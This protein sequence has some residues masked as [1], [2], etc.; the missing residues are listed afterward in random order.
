[1]FFNHWWLVALLIVVLIIFGPGKLPQIGG[2]VGQ[3]IKE[4]RR[5]SNELREEVS[6]A[7]SPATNAEQYAQT[8]PDVAAAPSSST[9]KPT[10]VEPAGKEE[11]EHTKA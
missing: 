10:T 1:M 7:T 6:R 5:A 11:A 2:A 3:A 9:A 8:E 4:F